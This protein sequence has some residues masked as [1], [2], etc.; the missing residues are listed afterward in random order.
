MEMKLSRE[1]KRGGALAPTQRNLSPSTELNRLRSEIDRLFDDPLAFFSRG[2]SF[3]EG[4]EPSV[5]VY[6]DKDQVTIKAELPGM[7]LPDINVHVRENTLTI[8]GER[9]SEEE[10]QEGERYRSER[11]FGKFQR[12]IVLSTAIVPEKI[13]AKYKDGILT[14][15]CPKSEQAKAKQIEIKST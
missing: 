6:E 2:M 8:S 7:K 10:S 1:S 14:I 13:D 3:F 11:Y 5:D 9:K 4:W 15:V 12:S